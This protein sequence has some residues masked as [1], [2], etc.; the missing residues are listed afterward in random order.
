TLTCHAKPTDA[1]HHAAERKPA[2]RSRWAPGLGADARKGNG[3]RAGATVVTNRDIPRDGSGYSRPESDGYGGGFTAPNAR[4]AGV[5]LGEFTGTRDDDAGDAQEGAPDIR[6][7]CRQHPTAADGYGAK[8]QA[9]GVE[10]DYRAGA[11]QIHGLRA[12]WRIVLD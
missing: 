6:Q 11:G 1:A 2:A 9:G 12:A 3:L 8:I 10:L 4:A 5:G 7:G